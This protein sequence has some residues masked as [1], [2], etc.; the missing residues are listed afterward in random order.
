MKYRLNPLISV[1]QNLTLQMW[2]NPQKTSIKAV[3][4]K[5]EPGVFY[6]QYADDDKFVQ[7]L[8][9]WKVE[10]RSTDRLIEALKQQ[11]IPYTTR[12]GCACRGGH[13]LVKFNGIE[14]VE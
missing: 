10:L 9:E 8:R 3:F 1:S 14:V 5:L 12:R 7:S 11:G 6:A 13:L 4:V 2:A